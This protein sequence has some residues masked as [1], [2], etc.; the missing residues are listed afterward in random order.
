MQLKRKLLI[1]YHDKDITIPEFNKCTKE[2]FDLK[3]K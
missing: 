2:I 1:I 3:L